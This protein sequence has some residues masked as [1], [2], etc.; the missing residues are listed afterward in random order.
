LS[1]RKRRD[2]KTPVREPKF[3]PGD[4]IQDPKDHETGRVECA[5][6]D[7]MVCVV[8]PSMRHEWVHEGTIELQPGLTPTRQP[9]NLSNE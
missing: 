4:E 7:G 1:I 3:R 2:A 9:R 5:R 8:W 6:A